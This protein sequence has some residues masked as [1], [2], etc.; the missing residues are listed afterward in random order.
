MFNKKDDEY[1]QNE[2]LE[3]FILLEQGYVNA[4]DIIIQKEMLNR[5]KLLKQF[6]LTKNE[7]ILSLTNHYM[8]NLMTLLLM[9]VSLHQ[10]LVYRQ[11]SRY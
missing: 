7:S 8:T 9:N 11:Q 5:N 1:W 6:L 10:N 4:Y 2:L 3:C